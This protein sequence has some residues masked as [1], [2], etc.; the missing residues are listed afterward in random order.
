MF[1]RDFFKI[2]A[3]YTFGIVVT[4]G[5]CWMMLGLAL[6]DAKLDLLQTITSAFGINLPNNMPLDM[7]DEARL[8]AVVMII[9]MMSIG[10]VILNVFFS[11]VITARFIRP[12]VDLVLSKRGVL[13]TVWNASMPYVLVRMSNFYPADLVDVSLNIALTVEETHVI[14]G[15]PDTFRTYFTIEQFT[16]QRIL[17]MEQKMPWSIAVPGDILLSN[18]KTRAYPFRPGKVIVDSI[19]KE[20]M[21]PATV[22]RSLQILIQGTDARSYSHFVIHK[23]IAIDEQDG[24]NY[25]LHLHRGVFKSLPLQ[26]SDAAQ[27][28]QYA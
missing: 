21:K 14:N 1:H 15:T 13:S 11:A 3:L 18:S 20:G 27:L 25:T 23:N 26:I 12:R 10:L 17:V 22:K 4:L 9:A 7:S 5:A 19:A 28:E 2:T 24:Q 16:P 6:P 8:A